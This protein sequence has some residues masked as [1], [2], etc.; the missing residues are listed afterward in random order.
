MVPPTRCF[1]SVLPI[2]AITLNS[3]NALIKSKQ[4]HYL[5]PRY[6][7]LNSFQNQT[8]LLFRWKVPSMY[9]KKKTIKSVY[10]APYILEVRI[11]NETLCSEKLFLAMLR[12]LRKTYVLLWRV[13]VIFSKRKPPRGAEKIKLKLKIATGRG[14]SPQM[15]SIE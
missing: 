10:R 5:R 9:H 8:K 13:L 7:I 2:R 11:V 14:C 12:L 6:L 3:N 15:V 1:F 4:T